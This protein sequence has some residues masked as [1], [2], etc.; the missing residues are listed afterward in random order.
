MKK[1]NNKLG[2]NKKFQ[3]QP[4]S[5]LLKED[6]TLSD[7]RREHALKSKSERKTTADFEYHASMA[8]DLF[9][10]ALTILTV[11]SLEYQVGRIKEAMDLFLALTKLPE[12]DKELSTIIDK[13]G[14]FLIDND[15]FKNALELYMAAEEMFPNNA[16]YLIGSGYCLGKL[17]RN[18]D[19]VKK[20]KS[21]IELEPNNYEYLND[22]GYSL[23]EA[24][25]LDEN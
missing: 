19:S 5:M 17:E 20:Y 14:D 3:E 18:M 10:D 22:L 16:L 9:N 2:G 12:K 1:G 13:A 8:S 23:L 4:F 25:P 21:A 24:G 15:D 7:L 11:G 6:E